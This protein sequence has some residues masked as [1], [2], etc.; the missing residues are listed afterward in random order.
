M[1]IFFPLLEDVDPVSS[2]ELKQ[3]VTCEQLWFLPASCEWITQHRTFPDLQAC[4]GHFTGWLQSKH[5]QSL[6][7]EES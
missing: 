1:G 3:L 4:T 5:F 2:S 6:E 7:K